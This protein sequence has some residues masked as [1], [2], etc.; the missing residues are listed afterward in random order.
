MIDTPT[1]LLTTPTTPF[2]VA[3]I[4]AGASVLIQYIY[5]DLAFESPFVLTF[6]CTALFSIYLP[7]VLLSSKLGLTQNPP[8]REPPA[9]TASGGGRD[10]NGSAV[11]AAGAGGGSSSSICYTPIGSARGSAAIH[12]ELPLRSAAVAMGTV[13]E[14]EDEDE[15][16]EVLRRKPPQPLW[17]HVKTM[18]VSAVMFP[19]F[20]VA[21]FAYNLSLAH[22]SVTSNTI[23]STTSSLWTFLF[24]CGMVG[25]G[26]LVE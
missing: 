19:L 25:W 23:I 4:W 22:T 10:G 14:R 16:V 17:S 1:I 7:V 21:N 2:Q 8:F 20:F 5:L 12:D 3:C 24:R 18:R 6:I 13:G 15:D 26:G 11:G 9:A